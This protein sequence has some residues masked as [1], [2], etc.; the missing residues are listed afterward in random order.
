MSSKRTE[1][2]PIILK[3]RSIQSFSSDQEKEKDIQDDENSINE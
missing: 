3:R 2:V 1:I